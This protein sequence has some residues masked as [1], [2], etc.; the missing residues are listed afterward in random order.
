MFISIKYIIMKKTI[1]SSLSYFFL[2][3]LI[4][5]SCSPLAKSVEKRQASVRI[6]SY[7]VRNCRGLD[8]IT[9][10]KRVA[11]IIT[12]ISPDV[13]ALQELDSATTRSAGIVVLNELARYTNMFRSYSAS[14]IFQ[15]GKYGIGVLS[16]IEPMNWRVVE[17]PGREEKRSMLV[18]EFKDYI[19]CCTH[20][21]LTE[22]DRAAS[23]N[24]IN[25]ALK[26]NSKPVFLAGD[27]NSVPGSSVIKNM[28]IGWVMLN[29]PQ[30]PTIPAD[31]PQKC[32][33]FIFAA[34]STKHTF[35]TK[36][37]TVE[38]EPLAS[39]HLPVWVDVVF[40]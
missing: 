10:Y 7:N 17:L 16:K 39:D 27:L 3:I 35:Q 38:H 9:D 36:Q 1:Q 33:D 34:K 37:T 30:V 6:L 14:I 2:L 11:D 23:V 12:R 19:F 18:V 28:E 21:S 24:I 13:V 32:I 20:L 15:G 40:N 8:N 29:D 31:N 4:L 22:E 25:D 26:G 5:T